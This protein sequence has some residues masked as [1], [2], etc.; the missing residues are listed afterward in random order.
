MLA[1]F[2]LRKD[3]RIKQFI[4]GSARLDGVKLLDGN[5][6]AGIIDRLCL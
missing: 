6:M 2:S 5:A 4:R 3:R 1:Y